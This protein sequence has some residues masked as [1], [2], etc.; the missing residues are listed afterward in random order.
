MMNLIGSSA[1][2][3]SNIFNVLS[4]M[5][6]SSFVGAGNIVAGANVGGIGSSAMLI[7]NEIYSG[8]SLIN[9]LDEPKEL[10]SFTAKLINFILFLLKYNYIY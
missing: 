6:M 4:P 9:S 2:R 5:D 3:G 1:G 10:I 8:W 7:N